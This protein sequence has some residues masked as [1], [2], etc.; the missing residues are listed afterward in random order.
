MTLNKPGQLSFQ[1]FYHLEDKEESLLCSRRVLGKLYHHIPPQSLETV[2]SFVRGKIITFN[3]AVL[4]AG[5][6][7]TS[8]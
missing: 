6:F 3:I 5:L 2:S 8:T 1:Q 7:L 4:A